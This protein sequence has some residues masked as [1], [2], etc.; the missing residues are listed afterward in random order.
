MHYVVHFSFQEEQPDMHGRFTMVVS[1]RSPEDAV[2][3]CELEIR[4]LRKR[5]GLLKGDQQISIK[6]PGDWDIAIDDWRADIEALEKR[7]CILKAP[8]KIFV[9]AIVEIDEM[10]ER[11]A[12][13]FYSVE[14]LRG[15]TVSNT[16]TLLSEVDGLRFY[17]CET[18]RQGDKHREDGFIRPFLKFFPGTVRPFPGK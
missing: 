11:A 14:P 5:Q 4:A 18:R 16:W 3:A 10:P 15:M 17:E 6:E 2:D 9:D 1:A 7:E 13:T 12:M 8:C